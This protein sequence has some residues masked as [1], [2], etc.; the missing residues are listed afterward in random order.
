MP[1][2]VWLRATATGRPASQPRVHSTAV[3]EFVAL[4]DV[5]HS[6]RPSARG[7]AGRNREHRYIAVLETMGRAVVLICVR[8][9]IHFNMC[10]TPMVSA[11]V[12]AGGIGLPHALGSLASYRL[13]GCGA[14]HPARR[15]SSARVGHLPCRATRAS[16]PGI[17]DRGRQRCS[18]YSGKTPQ[19]SMGWNSLGV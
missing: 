11:L 10:S 6:P 9:I 12:K 15:V 2:G 13:E 4:A 19:P 7:M 5:I 8:A 3:P 17:C 18:S 16:V 1:H 14:G